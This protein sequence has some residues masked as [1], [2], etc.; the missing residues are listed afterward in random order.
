VA[1]ILFLL[2][3]AAF[4]AVS[5]GYVKLCDKIIGPDATRDSGGEREL[6]REAVKA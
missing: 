3:T 5:V 4:F 1:D 6:E 2:I